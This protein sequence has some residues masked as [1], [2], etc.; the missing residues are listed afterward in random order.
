[1]QGCCGLL[2]LL[3]SPAHDAP[4][5]Q[6]RLRALTAR[7]SAAARVPLAVLT[8]ADEEELP[9]LRAGL[10]QHVDSSKI[11]AWDL[12]S[13]KPDPNQALYR[14]LDFLA[15]RAPR[16]PV[17]RRVTLAAAVQEQ[18]GPQLD[19][20]YRESRPAEQYIAAFNESLQQVAVQAAAAAALPE[21]AWGFPAPD[22]AAG[23]SLPQCWWHNER[24]SR[25]QQRLQGLQLPALPY[26][27][28]AINWEELD[29]DAEVQALQVSGE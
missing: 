7:I 18:Y 17:L 5:A 27:R 11:C 15:A 21:A 16:M 23:L 4:A 24:V 12:I 25:A 26:Q 10:A 19:S 29:F 6:Q 14:A 9:A 28:T 1:M 2:L 3:A 20:L 13:L 22:A 8:A